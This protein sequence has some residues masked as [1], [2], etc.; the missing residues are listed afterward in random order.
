MFESITK[1]NRR[2]YV[3]ADGERF[4]TRTFGQAVFVGKVAINGGL[5]DVRLI[6]EYDL[7]SRV[8][9]KGWQHVDHQEFDRSSLLVADE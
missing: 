8:A 3:V 7:F 6:E 5:H 1:E 2:Y 4:R 9:G